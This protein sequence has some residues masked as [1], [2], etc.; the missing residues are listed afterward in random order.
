MSRSTSSTKPGPDWGA[1]LLFVLS[2]A[3]AILASII[4]FRWSR[5]FFATTAVIQV[6]DAPPLPETPTALPPGVTLTPQDAEHTATSPAPTLPAA[7]AAVKWQDKRPVTLL[8]MGLDYRDWLE[9]A[10][11]PRTDT[12]ILFTI[13]PLKKT[14]GMMSIPRD[15]W[16][17]IPGFGFS[18]INGAYRS[19]E[20]YKL[21][22]G[23]IGLAAKTV[24][25]FVGVPVDF[26]ALIDFNAFVKFFDELG[27]LDMHIREPIKVDPIGPGNTRI[28]EPGVQTL[29]GA[30]VLAYARN[31]Y[32]EDGDFDRSRRQQE[33]VLALREQV[34]TFNQLPML[35][36]KSP[37]LYHELS[38]GIRTNLTLEQVVQLALLAADVKEE[39]IKQGILDP[40]KDVQYGTVQTKEGPASIILPNYD[41][42]RLLSSHIFGGGALGPAASGKAEDL[43]AAENASVLVMNGTNQVDRAKTASEFLR[44]KGVTA[45]GEASAGQVYGQTMIIDHSGKPYTIRY[46]METLN[47]PNSRIKIAYDPNASADLELIV[48]NDWAGLE[49]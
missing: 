21:P 5:D 40:H 10:D 26:V 8:V 11:I 42:I 17:N 22:G 47:V 2:L 24:E 16:V 38:S 28:L 37:K 15:M 23:G 19:G 20:M 35:I 30:T 12:M 43:M 39:D 44:S 1:L 29:D 18:R 31:R 48:G 49:P 27:G 4:A 34:L 7:P 33:V 13:D 45:V 46:I 3:L 32:T 25:H 41:R 9:G 36:Q 14:A 6:G